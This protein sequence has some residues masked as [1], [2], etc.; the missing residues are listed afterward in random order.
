[1]N[2]MQEVED[3]LKN[4]FPNS[5]VTVEDLTGTQDHLSVTIISER[6][7]GLRLIQQHQLV[8]DS[9]KAKLSENLHAIK[10]KTITR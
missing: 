5:E 8:M 10:I 3:I 4:D 7:Q 2:L 1:M 6:F 9:L